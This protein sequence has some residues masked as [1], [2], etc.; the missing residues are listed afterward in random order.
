MFGMNGI[1]AA[2]LGSRYVAFVQNRSVIRAANHRRTS[3]R[4]REQGH[5]FEIIA[6]P[7]HPN[8]LIAYLRGKTA[9]ADSS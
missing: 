3:R 1:E 2:I 5:E 6:E 7:L 4:A 8:E 9:F